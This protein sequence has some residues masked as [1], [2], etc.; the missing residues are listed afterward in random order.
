MMS[1]FT[2]ADLSRLDSQ[3]HWY[4]D[5]SE[6]QNLVLDKGC[7][8]RGSTGHRTEECVAITAKCQEAVSN[9]LKS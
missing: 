4:W 2:Q 6:P 5:P 1:K 9:A 8:C 7:R 3:T